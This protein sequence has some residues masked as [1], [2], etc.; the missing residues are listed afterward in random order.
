VLKGK[1][2]Y[3]SPEQVEGLGVDGRSDAYSLGLVLYE[4]LTS[5]RPF[6]PRD[7]EKE[8]ATLLRVRSGRVK[9]LR[10]LEPDLPKPVADAVDRALR[11]WRFRRHPSCGAFA[12]ALEAAC[13]REG[14]LAPASEVAEHMLAVRQRLQLAAHTA[15]KRGS[16]S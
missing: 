11:P 12:D 1:L 9:P 2:A 13:E 14:L 16:L 3:M 7:G 6:A 8:L 15:V 10:R 4:M 5:V